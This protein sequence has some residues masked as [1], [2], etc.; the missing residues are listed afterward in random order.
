[1]NKKIFDTLSKNFEATDLYAQ[2]FQYIREFF[3]ENREVP[4][5]VIQEERSK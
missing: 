4:K 2:R 3:A 5:E 1:M